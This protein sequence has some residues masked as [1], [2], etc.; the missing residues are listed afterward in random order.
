MK[1]LDPELILKKTGKIL[2]GDMVPAQFLPITITSILSYVTAEELHK[3]IQEEVPEFKISKNTIGRWMDRTRAWLGLPPPGRGK[4]SEK[5]RLEIEAWAALNGFP[6]LNEI[7]NG[8]LPIHRRPSNPATMN[9][10]VQP[11][12][13]VGPDCAPDKVATVPPEPAS[14]LVRS[15]NHSKKPA[16]ASKT[17]EQKL[18]TKTDNPEQTAA[19]PQTTATG[20]DFLAKVKRIMDVM[21][22]RFR[23]YHEIHAVLEKLPLDEDFPETFIALKNLTTLLMGNTECDRQQMRQHFPTIRREMKRA[24]VEW[25]DPF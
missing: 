21:R 19:G 4:S 23:E 5:N 10:P 11:M 24:G 12:E 14:G 9:Q 1:I 6:G 2:Y 17:A 25:L 20:V 15:T 13:A 16:S 3:L 7:K 22:P 18:A 8:W